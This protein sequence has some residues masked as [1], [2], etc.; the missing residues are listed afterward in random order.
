[1][2]IFKYTTTDHIFSIRH[3][4]EKKWEYNET[5]HQQLTYDKKPYDSVRRGVLYNI[6]IEFRY[7]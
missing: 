2:W 3:R 6:L 4:L 5:I 1:M 7:P